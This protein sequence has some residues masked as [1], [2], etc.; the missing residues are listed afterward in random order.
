VSCKKLTPQST[1]RLRLYH[2]VVVVEGRAGGVDIGVA[3]SAGAR[4][5]S[6]NA[7]VLIASV[8]QS[9]YSQGAT[10]A[11]VAPPLTPTEC[12]DDHN[13]ARGTA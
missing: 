7:C 13:V 3:I 9:R 4:R 6:E 1:T 5:I 11:G 10:M 8:T 12:V 2:L